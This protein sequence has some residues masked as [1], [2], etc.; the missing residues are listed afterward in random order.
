MR[1]GCTCRHAHACYGPGAVSLLLLLFFLRFGISAAS[2]SC[3]ARRSCQDPPGRASEREFFI[4]N[5]LVRIHFI[6][7]MI[8]WTGLA[9][10]EFEF[11]FPGSLI[12]TFLVT[13]ERLQQQAPPAARAAPARTAR[14]CVNYKDSPGVRATRDG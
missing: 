7:V 8:W 5:L 6:I 11:S 2:S 1:R 9:P 10:W 4:D 13:G 12:P 3:G 14:G